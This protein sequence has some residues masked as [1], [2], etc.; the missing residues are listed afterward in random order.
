MTDGNRPTAHIQSAPKPFSTL[1]TSL[2]PHSS[3]SSTSG[4]S[5]LFLHSSLADVRS[6]AD[7]QTI[8]N[9][10]H[11]LTG[12]RTVPNVILDFTSL[13]GADDVSLLHAEGGL[14]RRFEEMEM[15]PGAR[16]RRKP[17]KKRPQAEP[18]P[19]V[20]EPNPELVVKKVAEPVFPADA[21]KQG[22][23]RAIDEAY[24]IDERLEEEE[25]A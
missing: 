8:Q 20:K 22:V 3:S 19:K 10:L 25:E 6:S 15:V 23:N 24:E 4:V 1:I 7:T 9:L 18:V 12:R 21:I 5:P 11:G 14:Q 16:K 13:G 17:P 2:Q